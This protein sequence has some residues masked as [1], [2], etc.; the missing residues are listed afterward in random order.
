MQ[1]NMMHQQQYPIRLGV[2]LDCIQPLGTCVYVWRGR[3]GVCVW[4]GVCANAL[5]LYALATLIPITPS[6]TTY[7]CV[8]TYSERTA[9]VQEGRSVRFC[10]WQMPPLLIAQRGACVTMCAL[11]PSLSKW[12][13]V[14][15]STCPPASSL[16]IISFCLFFLFFLPPLIL[17][18]PLLSLSS[19]LS[20][21]IHYSH[22]FLTT[23]Q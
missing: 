16:L 23:P 6:S 13:F 15:L 10:Y 11:L 1:I 17:L 19:P 3:D 2:T 7:T 8:C 20:L 9:C 18:S 4:V 21:Y 14:C 22:T 5:F 12:L